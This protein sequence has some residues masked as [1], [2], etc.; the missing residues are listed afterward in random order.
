MSWFVVRTKPK[1]EFKAQEYYN[2]MSIET[3]LAATTIK[4][5][6]GSTK[7]KIFLPSYLFTKLPK[8]DYGIVNSNPFTRDVLKIAGRVAEISQNEIDVMQKHLS[9]NY[10]AKDFSSVEVGDLCE[11][12]HGAFSGLTGEIVQK[13]NNKIRLLLLSLGVMITLKISK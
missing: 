11:I 6:S 1:N 12:P 5:Q 9:S 4:T 7:K 10:N 3:Y 13:T 2:N 8:L